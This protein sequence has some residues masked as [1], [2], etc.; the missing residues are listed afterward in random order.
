MKIYTTNAC[1]KNEICTLFKDMITVCE[2]AIWDFEQYPDNEDFIET[3]Q[4]WLEDIEYDIKQIK[5]KVDTLQ[6]GKEVK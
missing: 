6:N 3:A 5:S 4:F 1:I 2:A